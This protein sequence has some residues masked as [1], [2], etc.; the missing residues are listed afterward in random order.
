M[1]NYVGKYNVTYSDNPLHKYCLIPQDYEMEPR[2]DIL[3]NSAKY[4][5]KS[6]S[7]FDEHFQITCETQSPYNFWLEK[8]KSKTVNNS[9][10][11]A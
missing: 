2:V 5:H 10:N 7:A 11:K 3:L 9:K 8:I 4:I 1:W 6:F